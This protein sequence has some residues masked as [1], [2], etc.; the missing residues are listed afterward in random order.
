MISQLR[1]AIF[2]TKILNLF[3]KMISIQNLMTVDEFAKFKGVT[4]QTVYNWLKET[5]VK[6]VD[7][8][9][10]K[11]IDKSTFKS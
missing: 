9:G 4:I 10:K 3:K 2:I 1:L 8:K 7:F 6:Q 5:K 11:F